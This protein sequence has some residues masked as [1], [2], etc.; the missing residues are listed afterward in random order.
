MELLQENEYRKIHKVLNNSAFVV[1]IIDNFVFRWQAY[2][3]NAYDVYI[4]SNSII[5][6]VEAHNM[7]LPTNYKIKK[8]LDDFI[9]YANKWNYLQIN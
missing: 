4:R 9:S 3:H 1:Y 5:P 2:Y 8:K 7:K 6:I